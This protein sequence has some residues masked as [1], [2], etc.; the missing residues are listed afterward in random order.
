MAVVAACEGE[1]RESREERL[2]IHQEG[3]NC[4]QSQE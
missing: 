1:R 2:S 3:R 4:H